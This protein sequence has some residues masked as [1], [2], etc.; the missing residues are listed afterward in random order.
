MLYYD[1]I[2]VSDGIDV[3]KTSPSKECDVCH[4]WYFL[5]YS[6]KFRPNVCN[7]RHDLPMMCINLSHIAILNI[8][9]SDYHCIISLISKNEATNLLQNADLTAKSGTLWNIKNIF[10]YVKMGEEIITFGKTEIKKIIFYRH[11]TPIL[12][13]M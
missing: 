11:K 4:C 10:S 12:G 13:E 8:K 1:R 9:S 3:K 6:F 5:N 2:D 7:R